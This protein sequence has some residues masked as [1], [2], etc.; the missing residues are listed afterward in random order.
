MSPQNHTGLWSGL[1]E[2]FG[3]L[4]TRRRR[5]F[6]LVLAL[7]LTGGLAELATIGSVLP[8][9][10]LLA[11]P[12]SLQR[13][14]PLAKALDS[15]VALTGAGRLATATGA[16]ILIAIVAAAVRLQL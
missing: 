16:F 10:S 5:E 4:S 8:F 7:M 11:D 9:L 2:L 6:H 1:R 14:P 3:L 12:D 13:F 15:L